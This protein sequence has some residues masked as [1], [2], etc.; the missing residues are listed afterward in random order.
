MTRKYEIYELNAEYG[1]VQEEYP[2]Y[3]DAVSAYH[4]ASNPKTLYGIDYQ[5]HSSVIFSN[6]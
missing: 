5:G 2:S 3:R 1:K 4:K 6:G